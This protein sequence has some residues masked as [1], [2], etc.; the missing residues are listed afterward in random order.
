MA[1][2]SA[3][4]REGLVLQVSENN[5]KV[6]NL[7]LNI[8]QNAAKKSR[9]PLDVRVVAFGPGL[10]MLTMDSKVANRLEKATGNG[11]TFLAC[12]MTMKKL[13]MKDENLYPNSG[14]KRV[15]GGVIEIMRLQNAGWSYIRP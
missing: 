7:V 12:G 14:I 9:K 1:T 3:A 13:K 5:P 11:V 2:I 15:D 10:K 6:W 4:E 8:A